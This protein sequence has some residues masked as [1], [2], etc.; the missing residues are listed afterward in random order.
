MG[1]YQSKPIISPSST[2][3][4]RRLSQTL[5]EDEEPM[6]IIASD[7]S[8]TVPATEVSQGQRRASYFVQDID[9]RT[10]ILNHASCSLHGLDN[11]K[12]K[13][14][15]DRMLV[16]MSEACC[17]FGVFDGHGKNGHMCSSYMKQNLAST[18][19]KH[20]H[21]TSNTANAISSS[22]MELEDGMTHSDFDCQ[23][24]GTTATVVL[25]TNTR[26]YVA[27]VG[28]SPGFV[29]A[30]NAVQNLI[31]IHNFE[32]S[33]E[34]NRI[35]QAGG[36]IARCGNQEDFVGP[37]RAFFPY[38]MIPGLAM[39][40]SVGDTMSKKIGI[41][42][43]PSIIV[44]TLDKD[45]QFVFL[46]SDGLTEFISPDQILAAFQEDVSLEGRCKG[47][48]AKAQEKWMQEEHQ[49]SDDITCL[50]VELCTL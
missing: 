4:P 2:I 42:S 30:S 50:V 23:F 43:E 19:I 47:L 11:G 7:S 12:Q 33:H 29:L 24:S 48:T 6:S 15:Q 32:D 22:F 16:Y 28:D 34:T 26:I 18:L 25:L 3:R 17:I 5:L 38:S 36:K 14:N 49:S 10:Y 40:R 35:L 20:L 39:S 45:D 8:Q 46:C 31:K 41:I 9:P 44:Y 37:L 13:V 21:S 27:W 1:C